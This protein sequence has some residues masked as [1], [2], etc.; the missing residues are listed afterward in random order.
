[1]NFSQINFHGSGKTVI[2]G[3]VYANI[4][5][6]MTITDEGVFVNGKPIEEYKEPF[7][8]KIEVNGTVE[9]IESE[10]ADVTV[11][12][13]V[14]SVVNKNG[15]IRVRNGVTGN[16]ESKNGNIT[17]SGGVGGDVTNKNGTIEQ[18]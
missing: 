7:V 15:N 11:N 10:N 18:M 2:N 8:V 17:V 14:G 3:K 13:T 5:G 4:S 16:V 9:S 6:Q 12:G 1:M